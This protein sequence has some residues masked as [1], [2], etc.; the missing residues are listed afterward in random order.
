M[1]SVLVGRAQTSSVPTGLLP[2]RR[3]V[4]FTPTWV[5]LGLRSRLVCSGEVRMVVKGVN[6]TEFE[7][8]T[9]AELAEAWQDAEI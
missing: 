9:H 1:Y 2:H 4:G 3:H 8:L 7:T 6:M 5:I